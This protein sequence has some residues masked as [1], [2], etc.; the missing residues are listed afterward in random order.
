MEKKNLKLVKKPRGG[1]KIANELF[2]DLLSKYIF[3]ILLTMFD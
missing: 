2:E 3:E 1:K